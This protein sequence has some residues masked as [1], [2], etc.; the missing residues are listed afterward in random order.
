LLLTTEKRTEEEVEHEKTRV[1]AFE[2]IDLRHRPLVECEF[3]LQWLQAAT[4]SGVGVASVGREGMAQVTT[5]R[6]AFGELFNVKSQLPSEF[7]SLE[8]NPHTIRCTVH[9]RGKHGTSA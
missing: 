5:H 3:G 8:H 2:Q 9:C 6:L 7:A 4:I 1:I